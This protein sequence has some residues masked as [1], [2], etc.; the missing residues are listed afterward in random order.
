MDRV[1][2]HARADIAL[3]S[4]TGEGLVAEDLFNAALLAQLQPEPGGTDASDMPPSPQ[5]LRSAVLQE[6]LPLQQAPPGAPPLHRNPRGVEANL[7][8]L[9]PRPAISARSREALPPLQAAPHRSRARRHGRTQRM[10][11]RWRH[12]AA[13]AVA[14]IEAILDEGCDESDLVALL[15]RGLLRRA[16]MEV[17]SNLIWSWRTLVCWQGLDHRQVRSRFR[18]R[19]LR[20][21]PPQVLPPPG[22]WFRVRWRQRPGPVARPPGTCSSGAAGVGAVAAALVSNGVGLA[23]INMASMLLIVET[24]IIY[25]AHL[26]RLVGFMVALPEEAAA[27]MGAQGMETLRA[28]ARISCLSIFRPSLSF[29]VDI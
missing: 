11:R 16:G 1:L 15:D 8:P 4:G 2:G 23:A 14:A 6:E 20:G 5:L 9:S 25:I 17:Q 13:A 21:P 19:V 18:E 10:R 28:E 3:L 7:A 29:A 22:G 27:A 12:S 24:A 26:D